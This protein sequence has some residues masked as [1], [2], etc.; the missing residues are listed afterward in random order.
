MN[1][2]KTFRDGALSVSIWRNV[3]KD[4]QYFSCQIQKVYEDDKGEMQNTQ[5]FNAKELLRISRLAKM[6]YDYSIEEKNEPA[7]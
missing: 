3:T 5:S 1:P 4:G 7:I 2:E 6:A